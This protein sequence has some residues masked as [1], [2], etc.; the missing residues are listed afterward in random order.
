MAYNLTGSANVV[1]LANHWLVAACNHEIYHYIQG[2]KHQLLTPFGLSLSIASRE[3]SMPHMGA[4]ESKSGE[5][6]ATVTTNRCRHLGP[7]PLHMRFLI[8]AALLHARVSPSELH[9]APYRLLQ[10]TPLQATVSASIVFAILLVF[11]QTLDFYLAT[12]L[13]LPICHLHM[14]SLPSRPCF[15]PTLAVTIYTGQASTTS[16]LNQQKRET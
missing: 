10:I 14:S 12:C 1:A 2:Y 11:L 15:S 9:Y 7:L 4:P 16:Q 5:D 8:C 13:A 3:S 6:V